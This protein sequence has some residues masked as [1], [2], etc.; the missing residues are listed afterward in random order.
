VQLADGAFCPRFSGVVP[1]PAALDPVA[2][3]RGNPIFRTSP[4][5]G[6]WRLDSYGRQVKHS[7]VYRPG[8]PSHTFT[9]PQDRTTLPSFRS[10]PSLALA[11]RVP[12][13][14]KA[15]LVTSRVCPLRARTSWPVC[16][17][18]T[19]TSPGVSEWKESPEPL[20]MRLPLGLKATLLT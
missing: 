8:C 5:A 11:M 19:F 20:T 10:T 17:S 14:L 4:A 6:Q 3:G 9:S 16:K 18:H 15:T 1:G 12:S 7:G 13:G 2:A